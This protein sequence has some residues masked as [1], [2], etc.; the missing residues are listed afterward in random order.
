MQPHRSSDNLAKSG[1]ISES[2]IVGTLQERYKDMVIYTN[3]GDILVAINPYQVQL[4][5]LVI[6]VIAHP[7][8]VPAVGYL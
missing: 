5:P 4:S 1:E 6:A 2:Y 8:L 7:Q 3:V